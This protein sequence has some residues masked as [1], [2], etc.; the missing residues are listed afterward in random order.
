[1][2]LVSTP[3]SGFSSSVSS[4]VRPAAA[5]SLLPVTQALAL[6]ARAVHSTLA[7]IVE[8]AR[9][10]AVGFVHKALDPTTIL[11]TEATGQVQFLNLGSA[12][13]LTNE[14]HEVDMHLSR[15]SRRTW[16]YA[17]PES[18]GRANR[19]IDGRSDLYSIGAILHELISG[20]PPFVPESNTAAMSLE[21]IH[22]HLAK[23]PPSVI[24]R[25]M[26]A[27][28]HPVLSPLLHASQAVLDKA[29]KK[30]AEE[31]YQSTSGF[32]HDLATLLAFFCVISAQDAALEAVLAGLGLL[33]KHVDEMS[34]NPVPAVRRENISP[35]N[36]TAGQL[37]QV[38]TFRLSQRLYG[39]DVE[40]KC[41]RSIYS[42]MCASGDTTRKLRPSF[43]EPLQTP[44]KGAGVGPKLVLL[45]G[46]SGSGKSS[47]VNELH[48]HI[49]ENRGI[50]ARSK[51]DQ[52]KRNS[53]VLFSAF[54]H[55]V[56]QLI[57]RDPVV[58][59]VKL[60]DAL[61]PNASVLT[62]VLPELCQLLGKQ[63][64]V[65]KLGPTETSNRFSM[66]LSQF[67][68]CVAT[69]Q[70]PVVVFIDDLQWSDEGSRSIINLML[71]LD[72][73]SLLIIGAF[74]DNECD[75][76]HGLT[77]LISDAKSKYPDRVTELA[78]Q[79]LT[80]IDI[81]ELLVDSFHVSSAE[82][83]PLAQLLSQRTQGNAFFIAQLLKT[84]SDVGEIKFNFSL[85]RWVWDLDSIRQTRTQEDVVDIV[86]LQMKALGNEAQTILQ[87][88]SC[89]G[90]Q[91]SLRLLLLATQFPL[92]QLCKSVSE[93]E[94]AGLLLC[95]THAA[96][97]FL[98]H[99]SSIFD[100]CDVGKSIGSEFPF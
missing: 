90:N 12:S 56:L 54:R 36:F 89:S 50:L 44:L 51:F 49:I 92:Q 55:L 37:D 9:L 94:N 8:L 72:V 34:K 17:S 13:P 33:R 82:A 63:P 30:S 28:T 38:S 19:S 23:L 21:L 10:H 45:F 75:S 83:S 3:S 58:W 32:L 35:E 74:R 57:V 69:P 48:Q 5:L 42:S 16:L 24:P 81:T 39:R 59:K 91:F 20:S 66:V 80:V 22:C 78:L 29:L 73:G 46:W 100:R 84:W 7:V 95:L 26:T 96:D 86:L 67:L 40:I 18:S 99:R 62:D 61:G 52:W 4:P 6:V 93:L 1:M 27:S 68:I 11:F 15:F 41:L 25:S 31:R 64:E 98:A 2:P 77:K 70:C 60:L 88:A 85:A 79:P 53:S 14:F 76:S 87:Y 97:L 71:T 65:S 47:L 43:V